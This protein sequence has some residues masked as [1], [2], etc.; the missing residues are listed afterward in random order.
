VL[1][2]PGIPSYSSRARVRQRCAP[3]GGLHMPQ[4][5]GG[6]GVG[7][8]E[9][10]GGKQDPRTNVPPGTLNRVELT[11]TARGFEGASLYDEPVF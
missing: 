3:G 11:I 2:E 8:G 1:D 9:E 7:A 5:T 4:Q 10:R 6:Q